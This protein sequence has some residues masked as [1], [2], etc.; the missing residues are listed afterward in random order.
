MAIV[1]IVGTPGS[2]KSTLAKMLATKLGYK[3]YSMGDLR[4]EM[5]T[6]RGMSLAEMNQ[7]SESGE[8]DTDTPVEQH[9]KELG[10]KENDFVVDCRTGPLMIPKSIKIYIDADERVRA[11]RLLHSYRIAEEAH[12]IEEAMAMNKARVESGSM[13]YKKYYDFDPWDTKHYDLVLDST[14]TGPDELL[15]Q[16]LEKFPVLQQ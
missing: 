13:R 8:E 14:N 15:Q 2:G 9:L 10:Q 11:D 12:S 1:T 16:V 4:R 7:R 6:E 3:H 5:A